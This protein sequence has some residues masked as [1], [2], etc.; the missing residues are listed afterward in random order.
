MIVSSVE[1]GEIKSDPILH[2]TR[3]DVLVKFLNDECSR[4]L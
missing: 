2:L 1:E 4:V 3:F